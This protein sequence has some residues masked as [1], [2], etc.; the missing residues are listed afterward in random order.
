MSRFPVPP[1]TPSGPGW[2]QICL[3]H[4]PHKAEAEDLA[5]EILVFLE[6]QPGVEIYRS[7]LWEPDTLRPHLSYVDG[8]IA[9]GGDGTMLRAARSGSSFGVP[10]LGINMGRV[11]FLSEVK[12]HQWQPAVQALLDGNHWIE[13]RLMIKVQ[14]LRPGPSGS[15]S[16]QTF[17]F[18]ALND[19]VISRGSLARVIETRIQLNGHMLARIICDG[20]IIATP[21]GSTGYALAAGGPIL[22]PELRNFVVVPVAPH[23]SLNRPL[24]LSEG[25]QVRV[26]AFW[27]H[28]AMLTVDG[29]FHL[30]M[31][32]GDE[33]AVRTNPHPALFART[34][35]RY[36]FYQTLVDRLSKTY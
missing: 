15:E 5:N 35:G 13:E 24:V 6:Q 36:D 9:L 14:V 17:D 11:G 19:A 22:P 28:E 4:H 2:K 20:L 23:L 1:T 3:L 25:T 29:H 12:P 31:V 18:E 10:V 33:V 27:D 30:D 8:I 32:E 21:T 26:Q 16:D 34:G 7:S